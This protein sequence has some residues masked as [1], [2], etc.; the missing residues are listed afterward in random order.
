MDGQVSIGPRAMVLFRAFVAL[1]LCCG[2]MIP[3]NLTAQRAYADEGSS[4][5]GIAT[6]ADTSGRDAYEAWYNQ[7]GVEEQCLAEFS[8]GSVEVS[9][10][11]ATDEGVINLK[12]GE[13]AVITVEPYQHV[14]YIGCCM[15]EKCPFD[16]EAA[17][18]DYGINCFE[19]G[20]G[21]SCIKTPY[22]D[23]ATATTSSTEEGIVTVS[24]LRVAEG[25]SELTTSDEVGTTN[26]GAIVVTAVAS[27]TTE[28]SIETD[29]LLFWYDGSATY[30]INVTEDEPASTG[31]EL[32]DGAYQLATAADLQ[33]FAD[34]V[35]GTLEDGDGATHYDANATLTAD[36]VLEDGVLPQIGN[37]ATATNTQS[38]TGTFDG[39]GHSISGI[40]TLSALTNNHYGFFGSLSGTVKNLTLEGSYSN[41]GSNAWVGVFAYYAYDNA[42]IENC[43]NDVD[44]TAG[45]VGGFVMQ[46]QKGADLTIKGCTNKGDIV[47]TNASYR[48]GGILCMFNL[49]GATTVTISQCANEGSVSGAGAAVGGIVG[50]RSTTGTL[51]IDSCVNKGDISSTA[52]SGTSARYVGGLVGNAS[53]ASSTGILT[54]TNSYN[55]GAVSSSVDGSS[56]ALGGLVGYG[57]VDTLENA[58]NIGCVSGPDGASAGYYGSIVGNGQ[59]AVSC[60]NV[61]YLADTCG[62][63][64][65]GTEPAV[66]PVE[67]TADEI[68]SADLVTALGSAFKQGASHPLLAWEA[69]EDVPS[70]DPAG[71][72]ITADQKVLLRQSG[73]TGSVTVS[74]ADAPEGWADAVT[75]VSV[76][77]LGGDDEG[78]VQVLDPSQYTL[79][80]NGIA[81]IRTEDAPVFS[82]QPGE[83]D[84]VDIAGR[85]GTTTYPNSKSYEITISADGYADTVGEALFYT[86]ASD[87]FYVAVDDNGNGQTD[88]GEIRR[89]FTAD[90]IAEMSSFQ[91]G[92]SQ[93]GMTGFR[94]FSA[95]GV[96]LA[97]LLEA[98]GVEPA[99]TDSYYLDTT[100]NFGSTFTY[101]QMF[102]TRY[103]LQS[104][105]DDQD[106]KDAYA[107]LVA[108]DDQAG[109]TIELRKLLAQKALEE[110][111]YAT[112]MISANYV[113]TLVSGDEVAD[114]VLPTEDNTTINSLVGAENQYRFT[115]GIALV[116]EDCTVT[117]DTG[118]GSDVES[119]TVKSHLMTSTENTTIKSTYWNNGVL[120]EPN[121]AEAPE[122]SAAADAL[123]VPDDPTREGYEFAG[124]WTKDGSEDGDWGEEFDFS[125]NDGTVDQD[126][127][128]YAKWVE[129]GG[130]S[131]EGF[132]LGMYVDMGDE[133]Y[134]YVSTSMGRYPAGMVSFTLRPSSDALAAYQAD[135][136]G[137]TTS[138]MLQDWIANVTSVT[139]D[140][141]ELTGKAFDEWKNELTNAADDADTLKYYELSG[142]SS[143]VSLRLPIALF[144]TNHTDQQ[145]D[146]KTVT[147][148]S[149][150]FATFTG[151]V[152]YR[153]IGTDTF[154][155]RVLDTA[156]N[157]QYTKTFTM[158]ELEALS[159]QESY[160]TS[161]NCGMAGLRSYSSEGVL[162]TDVLSAANVTFGPGMTLKLRCSDQIAESGNGDTTDDAYISNGTFTYEDLM[163]DRY[164][165]PAMWDDATT[166]DELDGQ[167]I[168]QV[169]S[170]D[171]QAWKSGGAYADVLPQLLGDSKVAVEPLIAFAWNEGVVAWGGSDP[172]QAEGYNGYSDQENF[173]FL[174]GML[175]NEDGSIAD[176]NTTFSNT[177]AL[178]GIDIIADSGAVNPDPGTDEPGT[179]NPGADEPGTGADEPGSGVDEPG[180]GD[181]TTGDN[182]GTGSDTQQQVSGSV[183]NGGSTSDGSNGSQF[184]QT[185]DATPV[186]PIACAAIA[187]AVLAFVAFA[188]RHSFGRGGRHVR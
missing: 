122:E 40:T 128:L 163:A 54:I 57:K 50:Y 165:Y 106:M 51:T 119:Q 19:K 21:C 75:S 29:D 107:E 84:P 120:V 145:T 158:D 41:S 118:E 33:W 49:N 12:V 124:W 183:N 162:L 45:Q 90:E 153:N 171:M 116:K 60:N 147:I 130:E 59:N 95:V 133:G 87:T 175:A 37:S 9:S 83:G 10:A 53:G 88:E 127:A 3:A 82:V 131:A 161:A 182:A 174:F 178:F 73:D 136:D 97:D 76:K 138:S 86:G 146:T 98:A 113:E 164:Y 81:F 166:Y 100:D 20:K 139:I 168:Y 186:V 152:T 32:V 23:Q 109:A 160:N 114:A 134:E 140:G 111:S 169:L 56:V 4:D 103:F 2:L 58:F 148:E 7:E 181:V 157:V 64:V 180:S 115:Y 43:V 125:A 13:T 66:A 62:A 179:D 137:A 149:D 34:Y 101:D 48:A 74:L 28:L 77:S 154:T 96:S 108:S 46:V 42:V 112:P 117:F 110:E 68:A 85:F 102:G 61:Y 94:T 39:A 67:K 16:C 151:D 38:Y 170:Q 15:P 188:L 91:N 150:G 72:S 14:Q 89:T 167:T 92:S 123:T 99:E 155:V 156:G 104:I 187:A 172:S 93:C 141:V 17:G 63:A 26:K 6:L 71:A 126:T 177:Y 25:S 129:D 143:S 36:I 144:A 173:R 65:G 184:A 31:P 35:N 176:D 18:E 1:V 135:H 52:T 5:D 55:A 142:L 27:G 30:T 159:V 78:A 105:Y 44:V 70:D 121:T 80:S 132:D 47:A 185:N 69:D 24:D 79:T 8:H 22:V 11:D